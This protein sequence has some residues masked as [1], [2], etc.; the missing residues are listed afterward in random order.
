MAD[1]AFNQ[2]L[3]K[4]TADADLS[5]VKDEPSLTATFSGRVLTLRYVGVITAEFMADMHSACSMPQPL[6]VV[7]DFTGADCRFTSAE[8][9]AAIGPHLIANTGSPRALLVT[10]QQ[11][12]LFKEH[13]LR[14]AGSHAVNQ[15][16]FYDRN[17]AE[18]WALEAL[19]RRGKADHPGQSP[20]GPKPAATAAPLQA[21]YTIQMGDVWIVRIEGQLPS[22]DLEAIYA[23]VARVNVHPWP[24]VLDFRA[25]RYRL[26]GG[27]LDQAL[28]ACRG[29]GTG[30]PT[31]LLA[32]EKSAPAFGQYAARA[33]LQ[34]VRRRVFLDEGAALD[35][36]RQVGTH[37]RER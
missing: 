9:D 15:R 16:G 23:E 1:A 27:E 6:P 22:S 25:A 13:A 29:T 34:G 14:F 7:A 17:R 28:P 8:L 31:A 24:V 33:A 26:T 18:A 19:A 36:A 11:A 10:P 5:L 30:A 12:S 3:A 2:F 21:R 35:W 4:L 37:D 32:T 20:V